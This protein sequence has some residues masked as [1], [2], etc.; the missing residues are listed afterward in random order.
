MTVLARERPMR[1]NGFRVALWIV[2][3]LLA[4]AFFVVG[5]AKAVQPID[6]LAQQM[7]WVT[8]VPS[9]LVRFIGV[10]E[11]AGAVGLVLPAATRIAPLLTPI[12]ALGLLLVMVLAAGFHLLRGEIAALPLNFVL[13]ALAAFVMW[14]RFKKA[15]I[16]ARHG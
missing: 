7:A 5:F 9:G 2:Q 10:M 8:A 14:G 13:G 6:E 16:P 15:P 12:A 1:L 4:A 3:V 11:I